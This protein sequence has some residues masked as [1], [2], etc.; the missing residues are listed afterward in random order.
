ML[1]YFKGGFSIVTNA[2]VKKIDQLGGAF[3]LNTRIEGIAKNRKGYTLTLP[4]NKQQEADFIL[5]ATPSDITGFILQPLAENTAQKQY[6]K[7]LQAIQYIGAICLV[8][9]SKQSLSE[10]YWHNVNDLGSPFLAFIQHTN[11]VDKAT[12]RGRHVYYLATYLP[13]EHPYFEMEPARLEAVWFDYLQKIVPEFDVGK[14]HEKHL[15][16]FKKAQHL[17]FLNY[18]K[19]LPSHRSP[20]PNIFVTNFAQIY[21]EDRGTNYAIR[22]GEMVAK[23]IADAAQEP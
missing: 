18:E 5:L 11:L 16:R 22:D 12:Y 6:I 23:L 8:F 4:G 10:Y 7:S 20:F 21:P 19:K 17:A 3:L 9:S 15:F 13:H 2:M 1:G 14:I